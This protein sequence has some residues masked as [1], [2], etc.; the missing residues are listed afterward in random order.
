MPAVLRR[1]SVE[2]SDDESVA[3]DRRRFS[4]WCPRRAADSIA[5]SSVVFFAEWLDGS[6]VGVLRESRRWMG[7][8]VVGWKLGSD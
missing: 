8:W 6:L 2:N 5:T 7:G 1:I 4:V 3:I